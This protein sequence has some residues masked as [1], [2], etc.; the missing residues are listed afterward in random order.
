MN[1]RARRTD[2]RFSK[3]RFSSF[4]IQRVMLIEKAFLRYSGVSWA[5]AKWEIKLKTNKMILNRD[6]NIFTNELLAEVHKKSQ[7][8]QPAFFMVIELFRQRLNDVRGVCYPYKDRS[9]KFL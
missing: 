7:P 9:Y 2:N 6:M 4:E 8:L 5:P 1:S 3:L